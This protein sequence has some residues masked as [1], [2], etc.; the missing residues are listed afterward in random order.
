MKIYFLKKIILIAI[1]NLVLNVT[2][3]IAMTMNQPEG[4]IEKYSL[5]F[6]D[7]C[8]C[9]LPKELLNFA[10]Q[11]K[12]I[13]E[14]GWAC[15]CEIMMHGFHVVT[16]DKYNKVVVKHIT[17]NDMMKMLLFMDY[18]NAQQKNQWNEYE[19]IDGLADKIW[20]ELNSNNH[21]LNLQLLSAYADVLDFVLLQKALGIV[22][23]WIYGSLQCS[24]KLSDTMSIRKN[25]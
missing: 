14:S 16:Y 25:N 2:I 22:F 6:D 10:G 8:L 12:N 9:N 3:L 18:C 7:S 5:V 21:S 17:D 24:K 11:L 13:I 15:E 19:I 23:F 1:A 4:L 20:N